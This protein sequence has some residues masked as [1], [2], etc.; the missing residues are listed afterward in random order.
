MDWVGGGMEWDDNISGGG[1]ITVQ[2]FITFG[3]G[4][5]ASICA[6]ELHY[7]YQNMPQCGVKWGAELQK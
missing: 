2:Q 3:G 6:W 4:T 1:W 7:S 5:F